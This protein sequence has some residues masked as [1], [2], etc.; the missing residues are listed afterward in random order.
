MSAKV[1][2]IEFLQFLMPAAHI[3][4]T[5]RSSASTLPLTTSLHLTLTDP[6][7]RDNLSRPTAKRV[8]FFY[9]LAKGI[10]IFLGNESDN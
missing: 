8:T 1:N 9:T 4:T 2:S 6:T 3:T 7:P 5:T 10:R